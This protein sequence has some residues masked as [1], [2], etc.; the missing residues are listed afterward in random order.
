MYIISPDTF[1]K[2][3][4]IE[5]YVRKLAEDARTLLYSCNFG[6]LPSF[7]KKSS[8]SE[9]Y[10]YMKE[11]CSELGKFQINQFRKSWFAIITKLKYAIMC[12]DTLEYGTLTPSNFSDAIV[13]KKLKYFKEDKE[14]YD[15]ESARIHNNGNLMMLFL[16]TAFGDILPPEDSPFN[17]SKDDLPELIDGNISKSVIYIFSNFICNKHRK[18]CKVCKEEDLAEFSYLFSNLLNTESSPAGNSPSDDNYFVLTM[19]SYLKHYG[20]C[21]SEEQ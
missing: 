6:F 16:C 7:E 18:N 11:N 8:F 2:V 12:A 5:D 17:I 9:T 10:K 14:Y 19:L 20:E 13:C 21:P 3:T 1:K 4:E 15:R